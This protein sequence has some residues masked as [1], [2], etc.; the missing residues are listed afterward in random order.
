MPRHALAPPDASDKKSGKKRLARNH[1]E[2]I[3]EPMTHP[4]AVGIIVIVNSTAE[5]MA[6]AEKQHNHPHK[7]K[8][9]KDYIDDSGKHAVRIQKLNRFSS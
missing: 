6:Y 5:K 7:D 1:S 8:Q 9:H 3:I 2:I 4:L